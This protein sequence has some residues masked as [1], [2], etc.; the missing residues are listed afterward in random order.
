MAKL[1]GKQL[2]A[3]VKALQKL[4][5]V[6][7]YST[8]G[9]L[10]EN[11]KKQV[12]KLWSK[13]SDVATA[14]KSD[15]SIVD[16]KD[17]SEKAIKKLRDSGYK[18]ANGKAAI[19]NK[20]FTD[21]KIKYEKMRDENGR[22]VHRMVIE[23][24]APGKMKSTEYITTGKEFVDWQDRII[25]MFNDGKLKKGEAY[26]IQFYDGGMWRRKMFI[27]PN[28]I[29][30]YASDMHFNTDSESEKNDLL[31]NIHLIK[32]EGQNRMPIRTPKDQKKIS[33][34]RSKKKS[35]TGTKK[36]SNTIQGLQS[37]KKK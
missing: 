16:T 37:R 33:R 18:I 1:T 25:Q 13:W 26:G 28:D 22:L 32:F 2:G 35:A 29:F 36:K 27:D 8:K 31:N 20:G 3:R 34:E 19:Y 15:V 5:Y 24:T 11:Q 10:S 4:G 7:S 14:A 9:D 12:G 21:S 30:H 17:L 6:K 23:R